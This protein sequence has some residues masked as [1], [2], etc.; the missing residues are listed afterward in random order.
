MNAF[1]KGFNKQ[2]AEHPALTIAKLL[3]V[4]AGTVGGAYVGGG[5]GD[6][7]KG[8]GKDSFTNPKKE[9]VRN[10]V[11]NALPYAGLAA[12]AALGGRASYK[13]WKKIGSFNRGFDQ[14]IARVGEQEKAAAVTG[15]DLAKMLWG[16]VF[17][18]L[19]SDLTRGTGLRLG[20]KV[21]D[22]RDQRIQDETLS[23]VLKDDRYDESDIGSLSSMASAS[24]VSQRAN[25]VATGA[26]SLLAGYSLLKASKPVINGKPDWAA[27]VADKVVTRVLG[28]GSKGTLGHLGLALAGAALMT[29]AATALVNPVVSETV[30]SVASHLRGRDIQKAVDYHFD[31]KTL[32]KATAGFE[33]AK[34]AASLTGMMPGLASGLRTTKSFGKVRTARPVSGQS[35]APRAHPNPIPSPTTPHSAGGTGGQVSTTDV[36]KPMNYGAR[37]MGSWM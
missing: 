16:S 31:D 30:G 8:L 10:K 11:L 36:P 4:T 13:A 6:V 23:R 32:S 29:G 27:R 26:G 12:G 33:R 37:L 9:S 7:I 35:I 15:G 21:R 34:T 22:A 2:A 17:Q 1:D 18:N 24:G 3:G 20:A 5:A 14:A 28:P 25:E 19:G